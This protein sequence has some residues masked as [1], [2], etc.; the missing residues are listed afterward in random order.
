MGQPCCGVSFS[1]M[2]FHVADNGVLALD[3]AIPV[4]DSLVDVIV[5]ERAQQ[6]MELGIGLVYDF[7]MKALPELRGVR[8]EA[9]QPH[10]TGPQDSTAN[11]GVALDH[12]V[13]VVTMTAGV[14][15]SDVLDNSLQH[16]GLVLLMQLPEG[17]GFDGFFIP[18]CPE[19]V[20]AIL[21][22]VG[23]DV[24]FGLMVDIVIGPELFQIVLQPVCREPAHF[25]AA[26]ARDSTG[27]Q[28]QPQFRRGFFGVLAIN[29]KKITHLI[30]DH[31]VRVALLDAVVFPHSR[32]RFGLL[33]GKRKS[34][35]CFHILCFIYSLD[36]FRFGEEQ[37]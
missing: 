35:G 6:L 31:I 4:L 20:S 27:D 32:V 11:S 25:H 8:I 3:F 21:R 16:D 15:V 24:L 36:L 5:R 7:P 22:F 18:E 12:G 1:R 14:P 17:G 37:V 34:R 9:K 33:L 19:P 23:V 10:I 29:L 30:Q 2:V 13:L 28:L 26:T